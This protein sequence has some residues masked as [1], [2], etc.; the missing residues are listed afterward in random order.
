LPLGKGLDRGLAADGSRE[1][2]GL[3]DGRLAHGLGDGPLGHLGAVAR[4][5]RLVDV[6]E[7]GRLDAALLQHGKSLLIGHEISIGAARR[8]QEALAVLR[9]YRGRGSSAQCGW[10]LIAPYLAEPP[11]IGAKLQYGSRT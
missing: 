2:A 7:D 1:L 4:F 9:R 5:E 3:L 6:L 8:A 10:R 11:I